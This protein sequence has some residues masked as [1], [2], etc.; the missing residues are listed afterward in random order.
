MW[1]WQRS[2]Q[3]RFIDSL[4]STL[5]SNMQKMIC[6]PECRTVSIWSGIPT[7]F[8]LLFWVVWISFPYFTIMVCDEEYC[9]YFLCKSIPMSGIFHFFRFLA[10][11]EAAHPASYTTYMVVSFIHYIHPIWLYKFRPIIL[12]Y[13][14]YKNWVFWLAYNYIPILG[15]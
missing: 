2:A 1:D 13:R 5:I 15:I 8:N 14:F 6:W 7:W 9:C 10:D 3:Y 4:Y 12:P 11:V